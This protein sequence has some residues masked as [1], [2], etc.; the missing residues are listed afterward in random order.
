MVER[1]QG[2]LSS[3][4]LN[5]ARVE[6]LWLY[7]GERK[8]KSLLEYHRSL[9]AEKQVLY[10]IKLSLKT[11]SLVMLSIH[12]FIYRARENYKDSGFTK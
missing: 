10:R 3:S 5:D 6:V 4:G 2:S 8:K 11:V 1:G 7:K 9:R 12:F